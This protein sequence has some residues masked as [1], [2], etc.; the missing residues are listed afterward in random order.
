[1]TYV[2]DREWTTPV[3]VSAVLSAAALAGAIAFTVILII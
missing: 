2:D 1:M 3:I